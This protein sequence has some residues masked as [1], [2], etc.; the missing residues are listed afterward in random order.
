MREVLKIERVY[1]L[2]GPLHVA[3]DTIHNQA[4]DSVFSGREIASFDFVVVAPTATKEV[5]HNR[6]HQLRINHN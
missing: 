6:K 1:R 3:K 5:V 2:P 4:D